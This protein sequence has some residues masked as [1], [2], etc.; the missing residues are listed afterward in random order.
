MRDA[1]AISEETA[2]GSQIQEALDAIKTIILDGLAHGHFKYSIAC[3]IGKGGRRD[4]L[5]EAG[6]S[7]KFTIPE[8]EVTR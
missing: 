4:L 7:H 1:R 8:S 5:I 6:K 2:A 3:E